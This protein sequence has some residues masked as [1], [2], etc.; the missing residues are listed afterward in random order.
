[1]AVDKDR[2]Y[3]ALDSSESFA[4]HEKLLKRHLISQVDRFNRADEDPKII[5]YEIAGLLSARSVI[6]LPDSNPFKKVLHVAGQLELPYPHRSTDASWEAL[7]NL[8]RQL[9]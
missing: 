3:D 7:E 5:A 1:M 2:L 6:A 8:V 4:G 9:P